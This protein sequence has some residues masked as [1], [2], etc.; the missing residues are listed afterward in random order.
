VNQVRK[1]LAVPGN[2]PVDVSAQRLEELRKQIEPQLKPVLRE[3][4]LAEFDL[5][6]A[7][8][9]VAEMAKAVEKI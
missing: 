6:R 4:D 1:K 8:E 5:D 3:Q 7:F 9:V 2:E